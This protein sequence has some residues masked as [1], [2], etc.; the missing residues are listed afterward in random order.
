MD[1]DGPIKQTQLL[2]R[3]SRSRV[4]I[5]RK[6]FWPRPS[7]A[8]NNTEN[9][10]DTKYN[11]NNFNVQSVAKKLLLTVS[12]VTCT[13]A[14]ATDVGGVNATANP[15][16]NSSGSVTNQAIQVLQGPYITNTYGGGIQCQG[17]TMNLTP[18]VTGTGSFRR[19]FEHSYMDPVYNNADND[20][21]SIPDNPG[22]ILYEMPTRTG[23][24]DNYSLSLGMSATWSKPLDKKLQELCK[25]A[26]QASISNMVQLTAN[27]RLDFEIARL[28]NCGELM[29]AGIMFH[30]R[31]P[32]Y[33]VCADVMLV[34]PPGVIAPHQHSL[35][36][37]PPSPQPQPSPSSEV[38]PSSQNLSQPD[39]SSSDIRSSEPEKDSDDKGFFQGWRLPWSKPA[40]PQVSQP[41][42][43]D[44]LGVLQ[45]GQMSQPQQ[46]SRPS[47]PQPE[48]P[49]DTAQ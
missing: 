40:S 36:S 26:A 31:S 10:R 2:N 21:D 23:Q 22:Q 6:L 30:P 1:R 41:S 38:L 7:H 18:Y 39:L 33:S 3:N 46:L 4:S 15:I 24:T 17:P 5:Y 8:D 12:L 44:L 13:P 48:V 35:K 19:P 9:Y 34:Q 32:Y 27:K 25:A 42:G 14:Y 45:V 16:A 47:S 20:N 29:K 43:A 28:K 11:R 37:S 49:E